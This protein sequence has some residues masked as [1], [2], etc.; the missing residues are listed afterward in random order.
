[1]S[2]KELSRYLKVSELTIYKYAAK[3][4]IPA[5]LIGRVWRFN[6]EVIDKWIRG[7]QK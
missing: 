2:T 4:K 1:M 3:G 6:K 7:D 5:I